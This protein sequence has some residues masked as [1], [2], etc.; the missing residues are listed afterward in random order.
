MPNYHTSLLITLP[1]FEW[2]SHS[3]KEKILKKNVKMMTKV[4][5]FQGFDS[6]TYGI[7]PLKF[8]LSTVVNNDAEQNVSNG[9]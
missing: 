6:L 7:I 4:F 2:P 1:K 9:T 5:G 3:L 8:F